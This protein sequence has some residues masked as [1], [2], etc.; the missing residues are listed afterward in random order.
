LFHSTILWFRLRGRVLFVHSKW[1]L[2]LYA[3]YTSLPQR[4]QTFC[5]EISMSRSYFSWFPPLTQ[6]TWT[7]ASNRD[8]KRPKV[9]IHTKHTHT[10]GMQRTLYTII[11]HGIIIITITKF[12]DIFSHF[13]LYIA[14]CT[15]CQTQNSHS[16]FEHRVFSGN[17]L[18][19]TPQWRPS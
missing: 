14:Q 8:M 15:K 13:Q 3:I 7:M 4:L 19:I 17:T 16:L 9:H 1:L 11:I 18:T 10:W 12:M 5:M 2:K 6:S